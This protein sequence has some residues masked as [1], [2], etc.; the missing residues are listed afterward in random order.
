MREFIH[1]F[2]MTRC[3]SEQEH[4]KFKSAYGLK[5]FFNGD[6]KR[7]KKKLKFVMSQY[8]DDGLKVEVRKREYEEVKYDPL[9]RPYTATIMITPHKLL[10]PGKRMGKLENS[11]DIQA[12]CRRLINMFSQ[13]QDESDV[14]LWEDAELRRVD[15]TKDVRTPSD[16]YSTEIIKASK[17]AVH[18]CGYK[19]FKPETSDDYNPRW[20]IEDSAL[21]YNHSQE[22]EAKIYNKLH[23]LE[24]IDQKEYFGFGLI[25]FELTLKRARLKELYHIDGILLPDGL[26]G[27]LC[28]ITEDGSMLLNKYMVQALFPGAMLSRSVLKKYIKRT[29]MGKE[30][31]IKEMLR[32]SSWVTKMAPEYY[33]LYGTESEI[34]TRKKWFRK[35]SVSPIYVSGECPYIPSFSDLVNGTHDEKLLNFAWSATKRTREDR[36]RANKGLVTATDFRYWQP[37]ALST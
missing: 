35:A 19:I 33:V 27:L 29:N 13:I 15:I 30:K 26:Q 28:K 6:K 5:Y 4:L 2:S 18:T 7:G 22:V 10:T 12:A 23:D 3:F 8:A 36:L 11:T 1:T 21:F 37:E 9:S 34:A 32:Y 20:A 25:R 16:L 31:R 14:N 17:Q 24:D